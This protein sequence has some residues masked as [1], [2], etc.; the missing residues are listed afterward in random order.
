MSNYYSCYAIP[1]YVKEYK[2]KKNV[3]ISFMKVTSRDYI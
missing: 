1:T 2:K 3:I